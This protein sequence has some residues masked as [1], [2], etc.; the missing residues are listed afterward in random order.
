L[1]DSFDELAARATTDPA[2]ASLLLARFGR[3]ASVVSAHIGG[4][5]ELAGSR[6]P[7][8]ALGFARQVWERLQAALTPDC[9][10]ADQGDDLLGVFDSRDKAVLAALDGHSHLTALFGSPV[11]SLAVG[12]GLVLEAPDGR[13]YGAE[14][15]RVRT[16]SAVWGGTGVAVTEAA[17]AGLTPPHGVGSHRAPHA[18][19]ALVGTRF[20]ILQDHRE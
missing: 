17:H 3:E 1:T 9:A 4:W 18:L 6:G 11:V 16:L 20:H 5:A 7:A 12:A 14:V 13:L 19:E 10:V 8:F 2:A 15:A